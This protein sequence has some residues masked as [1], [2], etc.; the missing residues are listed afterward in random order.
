ML[1]SMVARVSTITLSGL[2]GVPVE[3]ETDL[4][5]G[6][7]GMSIVGMGNKAVTEAKERVRSAISNSLLTFPPRKLTVNLA[8]AELPKEGAHLD[9]PIALS[10]LVASG[11][12]RQQ[13]V[14]AA[15]FIGELALTGA[16]RPIRGCISL[17]EAAR[18]SGVT[19]LYV[20]LANLA[21]AR[22]VE[23]IEV[24]GVRHLRELF[25][26]LKGITPIPSSNPPPLRQTQ[27]LHL[28]SLEDIKGQPQAKRALQ[29]AVAGRHNILLCGPPGAGK[30]MLAQALVGLLP[31]LSVEEQLTVTK[32]HSLSGTLP[33]SLITQRPFRAPHH[34][35]SR[36]AIIGGG[37]HTIPGEISLA[38][39]G[40]LFLDELPEYPR[41]ILEALRQ[42][43]EDKRITV[44]RATTRCIYPA[45]FMLVATMN[46]CPCGYLGD[47]RRACSCT[48]SQITAYRKRL[49]GPLLDRIDLVV[50]VTSD[51]ASWVFKDNPLHKNQRS[52]VVTLIN[53]AKALQEKRYKSSNL[54]NA[55]VQA[56]DLFA[57]CQLSPAADHLLQRAADRLGLTTR[58]I[59]RTVRVAR[60]IADLADSTT[61]EPAH[62]AE[63]IQFRGQLE[64]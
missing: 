8:P 37:P 25:L 9:V 17:A 15:V 7:P 45:D 51:Q 11:Q 57:H 6:L 56:R 18:A 33:S 46:P 60:T 44:T 27:T 41:A 48:A 50:M 58:G 32:V 29:I 38:H 52:K 42:P 24:I 47:P 1:E 13:E 21:Q 49:S 3:V 2:D 22:L 20:P 61:I 43:L 59:V 26:H 36:T 30:T 63:A 28:P 5:Q 10:V 62:I 19:R 4:K 34:T 35:A 54:Y 40:V 53:T 39:L 31:P 14:D 55:S 12:L 16:V 64:P 23:G